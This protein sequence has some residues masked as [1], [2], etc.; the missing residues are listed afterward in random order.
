[1]P[2]LSYRHDYAQ[3]A[4]FLNEMTGKVRDLKTAPPTNEEPIYTCWNREPGADP[5]DM[6]QF[7]PVYVTALTKDEPTH[8]HTPYRCFESIEFEY[9]PVDETT[10]HVHVTTGKQAR[11]LCQEAYLFANTEILH[12][13]VFVMPGEHTLTFKTPT[14]ES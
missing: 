4:D 2:G 12:N 11:P 9:E 1:M 8:T 6:A 13:E 3:Q 10:F 14:Y 7:I 5:S